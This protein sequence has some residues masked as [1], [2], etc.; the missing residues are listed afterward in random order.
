MELSNRI[1]GNEIDGTESMLGVGQDSK[2]MS[3]TSEEIRVIAGVARNRYRHTSS[4][5]QPGSGEEG[6]CEIWFG[7]IVPT[8]YAQR[9]HSIASTHII[10]PL[11]E[12]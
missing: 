12:P 8:Y 6:V 4:S 9:I 11:P 1:D 5:A 3:T 10:I 2:T 7:A